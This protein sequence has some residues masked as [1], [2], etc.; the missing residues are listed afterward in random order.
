MNVFFLFVYY[1]KDW[2]EVQKQSREQEEQQ[3]EVA[4]CVTDAKDANDQA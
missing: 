1:S 3:E 2:E 4:L